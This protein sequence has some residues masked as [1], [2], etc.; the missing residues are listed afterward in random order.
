MKHACTIMDPEKPPA[1]AQAGNS[2]EMA[3]TNSYLAKIC[4]WSKITVLEAVNRLSHT[5]SPVKPV[6]AGKLS[7][8]VRARILKITGLI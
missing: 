8:D 1:D 4:T 2:E 5:G 6:A 3:K 7:P